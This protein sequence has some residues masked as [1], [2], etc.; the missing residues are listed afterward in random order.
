MR[1]KLVTNAV[2]FIA[3]IS[4]VIGVV[5]AHVGPAAAASTWSVVPSASPNGPPGGALA[6]VSCST[7]TFCIAVGGDRRG[8]LI[9]QWNGT[10]WN[11]VASPNPKGGEA[12]LRA[13]TCTST[14][15]CYAVGSSVTFG[16]TTL[17]AT[18]LIE[19]WDGSKWSIIPSP[20][21]AGGS[22]VTLSAVTCTTATDCFAV[23]GTSTF[24]F[25]SIL[26]ITGAPLIEHWDGAA[27][28]IVASPTPSNT[29]TAE[30]N[31]VACPSAN[32]CF[33]VGDYEAR[34]TGGALMEHWDGTS[35]SVV[36]NPDAAGAVHAI[37]SPRLDL[38]F[39]SSPTLFGISCPSAM[40]CTAVGESFSGSALIERWDGATWTI[41]AN[42][43]PRNA[44]SVQLLNVSCSS[45]FDCSAVGTADV[46]T[47][48]GGIIS[49]EGGGT[50]VT[51]H[52][53]GT[54]WSIVAQ[55]AGGLFGELT[56]VSCPTSGYCAAVGDSA[57][58]QQ[59]NGAA[60][61]IAP[62][63]AKTS[64]SHLNGV[65][66]PAA[67]SCFAVGSYDTN[68][69][70]STLVE[71]WNGSKW[72]I[73]PSPNPKGSTDVELISVS[74]PTATSC[75]AV[76]YTSSSQS[77]QALI[78]R[79]NGKTWSIMASP[80]VPSAEIAELTSVSCAAANDCEAVGV[81]LTRTTAPL[82]EHWNG[83]RWSIAASASA[84]TALLILRGVSCV[85]ATDCTAVGGSETITGSSFTVKPVVEH[86]DGT[87][88]SIVPSAKP[89]NVPLSILFNVSCSS[90][91]DCI[92]VGIDARSELG[93][94]QPLAEHWNGTA[95]TIVK[96]PVPSGTIDTELAGVTC[97]TASRCY[98]VGGYATAAG[99]KTLIERWNGTA[100][101]VVA[102]ASPGDGSATALSGVACPTSTTCIA[103]G[104]YNSRNGSF[105]LTERGS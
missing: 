54:I 92:A 90:A 41:V 89:A 32:S 30:L 98:A 37:V 7:A 76:G 28:T 64:Q 4:L 38:G 84:G 77:E 58:A 52:W 36:A 18:T 91:T 74:C 67:Q 16:P 59:W 53:N 42:P 62:F 17:S 49:I 70:S 13:V 55:P 72:A 79:W 15:N 96:T 95:W 2:R 80:T 39:G 22:D 88:W 66:C 69:R 20:T 25:S 29:V 97:R 43:T 83:S 31:G 8:T 45:P 24:S 61:S 68:T 100:F 82:I 103:V 12:E 47:E 63:G 1:R 11:F 3:C 35:W 85:A 57:L 51:E 44:F 21:P 19:H 81:A 75:F 10:N 102:S 23:G 9:E 86:W 94:N 48:G 87:K 34:A 50:P 6:G 105:T 5:A 93:S 78:E 99:S 46:E 101:S 26:T 104:A 27:W 73:V 14:S 33:A 56:G 60:W 65:A 71:H 40:S